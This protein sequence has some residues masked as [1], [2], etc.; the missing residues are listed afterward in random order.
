MGAHVE[1]MKGTLEDNERYCSKE[2]ELITI[3]EKP[4]QGRR[5][6]LEDLAKQVKE[7]KPVAEILLE[8][9]QAYHQYGRTLEKLEDVAKQSSTRSQMTEGLWLWGPTGCGKSHRAFANF[10]PS[11]HYVVPLEDKGWWDSYAGQ[12]TVIL[13][14][15]RGSISYATLLRMVDKYP[16]TVPRRGRTPAQ[17][18]STLVIVTSSLPPEAV[19]HNLAEK[20]SLTQLYRRFKVE[21]LW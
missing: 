3:G 5:T 6:D 13:D 14:D 9:P 20:D 11:T 7:G 17:F 12:A 10:L 4:K 19:Y 8:N 2:G 1:P 18:V 21:Q 15:F 16:F